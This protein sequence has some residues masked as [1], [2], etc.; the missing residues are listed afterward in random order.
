MRDLAQRENPEFDS[1]GF[2]VRRGEIIAIN[3][4]PAGLKRAEAAGFKVT[5]KNRLRGIGLGFARL[6]VPAGDTAATALAK[7]RAL[8][9]QTIF[10]FDHYYAAEENAPAGLSEAGDEYSLHIPKQKIKTRI[11]VI[12]AAVLQHPSLRNV[13]IDTHDFARAAPSAEMQPSSSSVFDH[14]LAVV[15]VLAQQGA[16]SITSANVFRGDTARPF[17]D[18][19]ALA[20][21]LN[22]MAEQNIPVINISIAGP[23]NAALDTIVRRVA[24]QGHIIVAAAGNQ[25]PTAPPAYPAASTGAIAVT[26]VDGQNNIYRMANRGAFIRYA[27]PGVNILTASRTGVARRSGTSFAAALVSAALASC[28]RKP[29][30]SQVQLCLAQLDSSARD[31]GLPGRDPVY[32]L[33]LVAE[34]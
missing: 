5:E 25:G 24:D 21:A 27:A 4:T 23:P 22:W 20:L 32:G 34:R 26:A 7:A 14:G 3:P 29:G 33:G 15:S 17:T 11:G 16:Q 10:D 30:Q 6:R 8:D 19:T 12:D 1:R 31:L 18:A 9:P 28:M 13:K 2:P